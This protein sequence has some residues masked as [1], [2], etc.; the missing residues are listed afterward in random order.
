MD[1]AV[2]VIIFLQYF[3]YWIVSSAPGSAVIKKRQKEY[4][5]KVVEYCRSVLH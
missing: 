2:I 4:Q 3:L 1:S 5:E